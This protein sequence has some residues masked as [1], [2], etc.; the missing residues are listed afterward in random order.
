MYEK[1]IFFFLVCAICVRGFFLLLLHTFGAERF[2]CT[3]EII[4][5]SY[6]CF[7]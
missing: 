7:R 4:L 2:V 6:G 3:L 5:I 1:K